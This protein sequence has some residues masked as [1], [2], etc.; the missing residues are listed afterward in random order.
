MMPRFGNNVRG[1]WKKNCQFA[2]KF[3]E[4][5]NEMKAGHLSSSLWSLLRNK[6]SNLNKKILKVV[7]SPLLLSNVNEQQETSVAF[8]K[9]REWIT[10][11]NFVASVKKCQ[12]LLRS[13]FTDVIYWLWKNIYWC[14]SSSA[15]YVDFFLTVIGIPALG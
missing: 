2:T 4:D 15:F 6:A 8:C 13:D 3:F 14:G 9:D 7:W 5:Y 12:G 11:S 10:C 1:C